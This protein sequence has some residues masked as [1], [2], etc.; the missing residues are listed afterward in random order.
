MK[1]EAPSEQVIVLA[2]IDWGADSQRSQAV[3]SALAAGG[4]QVYFVE[5]TGFRNPSPGNI[6]RGPATP[7]PA[8]VTLVS[9]AVLPPTCGVFRALNAAFFIPALLARLR[10]LGLRPG[11]DVLVYLP[12]DTTLRIVDQVA[13]DRVV[14]DC[15]EDFH[16]HPTPPADLAET[17]AA[18]LER[19][20]IVF[21]PSPRLFDR[22]AARH[23][24]V[25]LFEHDPSLAHAEAQ[26]A[27]ADDLIESA[28]RRP[29]AAPWT[30]TSWPTTPVSWALCAFA[31]ALPLSIA[32]ANVGWAL[33]AAALLWEW[34]L[35]SRPFFAAA[36]G[37]LWTPLWVYLAAALA[38][39]LLGRDPAH[40]LRYLNQ[41]VHKVWVA[42]LLSVA[43]ARARPRAFPAALAAAA[44]AA[45]VLG[46]WQ[47]LGG[48]G[49]ASG[50][51]PRA[52]AFVHPVT[53]G[54]QMG[55]LV[56][57]AMAALWAA[58]PGGEGPRARR[59]A[60]GLCAL[61]GAALLLSGTRGA[62]VGAAVGAAAIAFV[63]QGGRRVAAALLAA[64]AA[65]YLG[66]EYLR[67]DRAV[68][69]EAARALL[70]GRPPEGLGFARLTLWDVA[71]R[72]GADHP[73]TGVG[74][75]NYRAALPDYHRGMFEDATVSWGTAHNLYLHHFA[76]RGLLGL[77]ALGFLLWTMLRRAYERVRTAPSFWSYWAWGATAAFLVMNL[78]EVALQTELVWLLV[79]TIWCAAEAEGARSDA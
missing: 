11:P 8:G 36:R 21:T 73:W 3:A 6:R 15:V 28:P 44:A 4:R 12:T 65:L 74:I 7:P 45:A 43:F 54:G 63:R 62:M 30:G 5:N 79:W 18:L 20:D 72:M 57:G 46:V 10:L 78:T 76:E 23:P 27:R 68:V 60:L 40:S 9:P 17:E 61:L 55:L 37:P 24:N 19:A 69:F 49:A 1:S 25:H 59:T 38:A 34:R 14:Y 16:G 41:D 50:A 48:L 71:L 42:A 13:A 33:A 35:G 51:Q 66:M 70:Q 47:Y 56:L 75:N 31:L 58:P 32:G 22:A 2:N 52:H 64:G 67:E 26:T 77:G 53:Y 29:P 39:D